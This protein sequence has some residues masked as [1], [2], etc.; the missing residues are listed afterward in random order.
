MLLFIFSA[1]NLFGR[2]VAKWE[3]LRSIFSPV[4]RDVFIGLG[5]L[6]FFSMLIWWVGNST[7]IVPTI[8]SRLVLF[9]EN[10]G[11]EKLYSQVIVPYPEV[12][13]PVWISLLLNFRDLMIFVPAGIG[14]LLLWRSKLVPREKFFIIYGVLGFGF[15]LIINVIFRIEPLRIVLFM[16]PFIAFLSAVFFDKLLNKLKILSK[17]VVFVVILLL[18]FASFIGLW[19]HSFA[20]IHLY[21][22]SVDRIEIGE[23]T[24]DFIRVKSFFENNLNISDFEEVRADII[25]QLVYLLDSKDFDKIK[26]LPVDNFNQLDNSSTIVC[27]FNDLNLYQYYA[28][29]WSPIELSEAKIVQQELKFYLENNFQ[30]IYSDGSVSIWINSFKFE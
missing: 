20:P 10:L 12:L 23:A 19:G 26:S 6:T 1:L 17:T 5:L 30:L 11:L 15:I 13:R 25:S 21:D 8:T 29:V 3:R 14:L 28:Y 16:A 7:A 18:V 4:G 2:W 9:F 24:S 22:S 27:S